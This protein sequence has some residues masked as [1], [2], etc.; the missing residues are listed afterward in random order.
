MVTA[1]EPIDAADYTVWQTHLGD[2]VSDGPPPPPFTPAAIVV[3]TSGV[4]IP[5]GSQLDISTSQTQGLQEAFDYSAQQ[6][7]D[8]F[9]LPGTYTLNAH[10]DIEELQLRTFRMEDATLNFTSNVTDYGIRFDSTMMVDWYWN[11]GAIHAPHA[12][13][14]VLFQ[15]RT[16]HPLDGSKHG[17][18]GILD[19]RMHFAV[20]I[21]AG[22]HP[23]TMNSITA[24]IEGTT[25]HFRNVPEKQLVYSQWNRRRYLVCTRTHGR[26]HSVRL[27][28]NCRPRYG[29]AANDRSF[30]GGS[31]YGVSS[32]T[33]PR[34]TFGERKPPDFKKHST[35]PEP[36]T[37]MSLC[38]GGE[39]ATSLR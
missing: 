14:G 16:P 9:I 21:T 37:W 26:S 23:V 3:Q 38:S 22:T 18:N 24:R 20:D 12:T 17:T 33:E 10:L 25:F 28:L 30:R 8:L 39:F 6:G 7:W 35:M 2:L 29:R 34:L 1:T 19:S 4:S 36:T 5:D 13:H 15:P 27:V 11:G 31:G 32:R